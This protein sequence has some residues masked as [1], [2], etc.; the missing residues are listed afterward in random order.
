[1]PGHIIGKLP[2]RWSQYRKLSKKAQQARQEAIE[3]AMKDSS[4]DAAL[5]YLR[6][7]TDNY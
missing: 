6:S 4:E 7:Y 3:Q 1:M 2:P 5:I